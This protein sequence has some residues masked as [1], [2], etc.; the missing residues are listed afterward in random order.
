MVPQK[1][2]IVGSGI[3]SAVCCSLISR[4]PSLSKVFDL[5]VW[6]KARGAGGRMSTTR[7][8][9][10]QD[11]VADLGA[12]F[13]TVSPVYAQKHSS[14][15]EE[16]LQS[17]KLEKLKGHLEGMKNLPEGTK[18]YVARNGTGSLVKKFLQD[19]EN[20]AIDYNTHLSKLTIVDGRWRATTLDGREEIFENV[21]LTMPVP[22]ALQLQ[23]DV[24]QTL[25][26]AGVHGN[27]DQVKY[28]SR[29]ALGMFF[30]E[31]VSVPDFPWVAKFIYGHPVWRYASFDNRKRNQDGGPTAVV[32]HTDVAFGEKNV[33]R[34][35]EDLKEDLLSS[36]RDLLPN[37]PETQDVKC[38]K[39]RYSQVVK[40]Y[41]DSPGFVV[42][43]TEPMLLLAGDGFT[44][45][46]FDGCVDSATKVVEFLKSKF[47]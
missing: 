43:S 23:G 30:S 41:P 29:Y 8:P 36:A 22:Q 37:L 2:L 33:E 31:G 11:N 16:L 47:C 21:L 5:V 1:L 3:T 34:S 17:G 25:K 9:K 7:S 35:P 45:S 46:H 32:L 15:Y 44:H 4:D 13:I 38:Q 10:D 28:S 26:E 14:I 39:W 19:A 6:E 20:V 24:Q 42:G 12:Q 40:S 18:H 27:L